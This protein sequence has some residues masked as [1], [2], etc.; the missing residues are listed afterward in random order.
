MTD[1]RIFF[2]IMNNVIFTSGKHGV[3]RE[4]WKDVKG[5]DVTDLTT[6]SKFPSIPNQVRKK[7]SRINVS[8]FR[9][10]YS[11]DLQ[12]GGGVSQKRA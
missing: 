2:T 12:A 8:V 5:E 1:E 4:V 6:A 7:L 10:R 9:Y 11:V 3:I